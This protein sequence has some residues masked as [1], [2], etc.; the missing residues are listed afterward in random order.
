[1]NNFFLDGCYS[2]KTDIL[3]DGAKSQLYIANV[4]STDSGN[5][6]CS[7]GEDT[8]TWVSVAVITGETPAAMQHGSAAT[9][10]NLGLLT[11][12]SAVLS[13]IR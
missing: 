10:A 9:A 6:S 3:P 5:Y 12:L 11:L 7:L 8:M 13:A 4:G 1:M 2:V